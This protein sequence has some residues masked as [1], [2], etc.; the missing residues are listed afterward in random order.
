MHYGNSG[1][2]LKESFRK[3]IQKTGGSSEFKALAISWGQ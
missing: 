2:N 1:P 3:E